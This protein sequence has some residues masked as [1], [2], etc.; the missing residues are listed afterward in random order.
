MAKRR[1]A[2][3]YILLPLEMKEFIQR[4]SRAKLRQPKSEI[5]RA[6]RQRWIRSRQRRRPLM[7]RKFA[8]EES[9]YIENGIARVR[10]RAC[11]CAQGRAVRLR[12]GGWDERMEL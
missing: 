7:G 3:M 11:R 5:I 8:Q 1:S 9:R 6:I 12:F 2:D 4:R 10:A